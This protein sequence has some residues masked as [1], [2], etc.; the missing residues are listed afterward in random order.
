NVVTSLVYIA[1][2]SAFAATSQAREGLLEAMERDVNAEELRARALQR[3]MADAVDDLA[4]QLH[5]RVQTRLVVCAA[6]LERAART[7]DHEGVARALSE[8]TT[9]LEQ[10]ARPTTVSL[11]DV[12]RGWASLMDV[13]VDASEAPAGALGRDDVIAVVEEGLANAFRHGAASSVQI[14]ISPGAEALLVEIVD[15][16]MGPTGDAPG[17]GSYVLQQLSGGKATLER[18]SQSTWLTVGLPQ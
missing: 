2:T 17:L 14:S 1:V 12:L 16:G 13:T 18:R 9:A 7:G 8:A 10:A 15:D 6:E 3:E 11:D 4:R 5:G